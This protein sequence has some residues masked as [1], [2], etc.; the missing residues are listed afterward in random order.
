MSLRKTLIGACMTGALLA[1]GATAYAAGADGPQPHRHM[2]GNFD[3]VAWHKQMCTDRYARNVGRVAY[4]G[5]KLSLTDA[6]RPLFDGWKQAVLGSAKSR[7]SECLAR[8]PKMGERHGHTVLERQARM[9]KHLQ[10]RLSEMTAEQ[11]SLKAL[12]DSL[13]ADQ[14]QV[15]DRRGPMGHGGHD[16]HGHGGWHKHG[17]HDGPA[18]GNDKA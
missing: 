16:R 13:S 15:F 7:E 11:P 1:G 4:V 8:Q 17:P 10:Q 6:Q 3:H 14:K 2:A 9:Q 12:Y 18:A 5:A